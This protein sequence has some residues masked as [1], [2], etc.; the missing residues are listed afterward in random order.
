MVIFQQQNKYVDFKTANKQKIFW[1]RV[2]IC[3]SRGEKNKTVKKLS[4]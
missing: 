1:N 2:A 3:R 4:I